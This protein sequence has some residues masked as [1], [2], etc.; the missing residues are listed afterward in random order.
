VIIITPTS[1]FPRRAKRPASSSCSPSPSTGAAFSWLSLSA[2]AAVSSFSAEVGAAVVHGMYENV[3][4]EFFRSDESAKELKGYFFN[5]LQRNERKEI[6]VTQD[7]EDFAP[8]TPRLISARSDSV[9]L[10]FEGR[11]PN[12]M[13]LK[14]FSR[15]YNL[16]GE[17]IEDTKRGTCFGSDSR[18]CPPGQW[19]DGNNSCYQ[20]YNAND[21]CADDSNCA[22][23]KCVHNFCSE[24]RDDSD[25]PPTQ[26]CDVEPG[27]QYRTCKSTGIL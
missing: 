12:T 8:F 10:V 4:I 25:C 9:M 7:F 26:L 22:S 24:C 2:G 15:K 6:S 1:T 27:H 18:I 14:K 19:C 17:L 13:E 20:M 5:T 11:D 3:A 16:D 23:G 21:M